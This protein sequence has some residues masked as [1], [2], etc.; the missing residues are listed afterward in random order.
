MRVDEEFFPV[1]FKKSLQATLSV[2]RI[3]TLISNHMLTNPTKKLF[4]LNH[5][6]HRSD[7]PNGGAFNTCC[8]QRFL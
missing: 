8:L 1:Q 3:N 2:L 5:H 4:N 6:H 7:Y